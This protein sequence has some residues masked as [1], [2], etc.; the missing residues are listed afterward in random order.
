MR[1][2]ADVL[3]A[4]EHHV[5]EEVC[6]AG[7]P[8]ALVQRTDVIPEVDGDQRQPVIL[9][10]DDREPIG[11]RVLLVLDLRQ[12]QLLRWCRYHGGKN[13]KQGEGG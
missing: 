11:Q 7:A 10:R 1:L 2:L 8:G 12:L 9:M 6:E 13:Q 5:L 3:G 4:F